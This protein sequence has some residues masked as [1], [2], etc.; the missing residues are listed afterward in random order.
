MEID[1]DMIAHLDV[2]GYEIKYSAALWRLVAK[3][4]V[5]EFPGHFKRKKPYK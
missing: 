4:F 1:P 2:R 5:L 3:N